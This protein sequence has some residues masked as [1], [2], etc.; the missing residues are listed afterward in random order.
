MLRLSRLRH[1]LLHGAHSCLPQI[2]CLNWQVFAFGSVPVVRFRVPPTSATT[3][4]AD[5][6]AELFRLGL[7][8]RDCHEFAMPW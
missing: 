1:A 5:I 7:S 4:D 3:L 6:R 2:S 8:S